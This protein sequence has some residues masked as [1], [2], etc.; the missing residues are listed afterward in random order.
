LDAQQPVKARRLEFHPHV[1]IVALACL[2]LVVGLGIARALWPAGRSPS[3]RPASFARQAGSWPQ[4]PWLNARPGVNYVGDAVCARCHTD[5]AETFSRHPMGRSLAPIASAPAVG[6]AR[7]N[8]TTTFGV[9]PSVF[10]I[11]RRGGREIHRE[12]FRDGGKVLAQVE[13]EVAYAV[14][15]GARSIS[16]LVEHDGRL[17]LSPI[18]WYTQKQQWDLSPGFEKISA[19]FDRPIDPDC[20]FC[21]SNRVEPV[22]LSAN[23]YK[24]PIF[25]GHA[26]GCERCHG[27][28]EL[29][30]RRQELSGGRDLTI[31][32]PRHLDPVLRGNICEQCHLVGDR[33]VNR[34]GRDAF[35]YRPGLPLTEFFVDHSHTTDEGQKLVGQVEQMKASRCFRASQGRL[36]CISCHDPH[37]LPDPEEKIA[38]FRERCLACHE[39]KGCKL[40]EPVRLARNREDYCA[41]CHMPVSKTVDAVHIAVRDHRILREPHAWSTAPKRSGSLFPLVR[42]DGD[43]D[44]EHLKSLDREL[45]IAVTAEGT[46]LPNTPQMRKI[47]PLVLSALDKA[48]AEHPDDLVALRMKAQALAFTERHAEALQIADSL[49]KSTP[50]Y[51]LLL[52]DY[53]SYA[54]DLRYFRAALGP[55]KRAVALNP[56]SAAY[57]ERLAYVSMQCQDWTGALHE[58]RAALRLNPFLRFPRMFLVQCLLHDKDT[59][60]AGNEFAT[61]VKLHADQRESLEEWLAEQRRR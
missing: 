57:R 33:R 32:N 49:L 45:A 61:L 17:F 21:H 6:F 1:S 40:P 53:C 43:D 55:A 41:G 9:A 58:A 42:L 27:P 11:E 19:H 50:S 25:L 31:V 15:S 56:W 30:A 35:D 22:A 26:I 39:D 12:T 20:L 38:Y 3:A 47:G 44:P 8:G 29:H 24:A 46:R 34:L 14:G 52:D 4:S 48:V 2:V 28:G 60:A 59:K 10:T 5:I 51:E 7:P 54:I 37:E 23:L 13:G 16:Y 36:G 18:T